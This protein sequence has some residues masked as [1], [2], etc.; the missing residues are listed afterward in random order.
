MN[1]AV[2]V[3]GGEPGGDGG[4][5][6]LGTGGMVRL[7]IVKQFTVYGEAGAESSSSGRVGPALTSCNGMGAGLGAGPDTGSSVFAFASWPFRRDSVSGFLSVPACVEDKA[8]AAQHAT[9]MPS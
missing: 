8:T 6:K 4:M 5:S 9:H 2:D 3:G 1:L 7:R